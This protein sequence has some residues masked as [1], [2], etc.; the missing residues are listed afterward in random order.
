MGGVFGATNDGGIANSQSQWIEGGSSAMIRAVSK[1][2]VVKEHKGPIG[3]HK[4]HQKEFKNTG[5][6]KL[7][8]KKDFSV[9]IEMSR[10]VIYPS[11]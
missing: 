11:C 4:K 10:D 6:T 3:Y 8:S 1:V 7:L 9:E 2:Q 5:F